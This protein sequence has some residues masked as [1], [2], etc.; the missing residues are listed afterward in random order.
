M[1]GLKEVI[2]DHGQGQPVWIAEFGWETAPGGDWTEDEAA[3][4]VEA[5][6]EGFAEVRAGTFSLAEN[7][8]WPELARMFGY[9]LNDDPSVYAD[10][11]STWGLLDSDLAPKSAY[12]SYRS[13][14]AAQGGCVEDGGEDEEDEED[15]DTGLGG[16]GDDD[17]EPVADPFAIRRREAVYSVHVAVL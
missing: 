10:G 4:E 17:E 3:D 15:P 7:D 6:W 2:D 16:G 11:M 12:A 14:I 1:H 8:P 5:T 13:V 9:D